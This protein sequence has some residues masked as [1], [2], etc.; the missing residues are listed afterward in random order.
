MIFFFALI[1]L[2]SEN[3]TM[4][5]WEDSKNGSESKLSPEL[6][7]GDRSPGGRTDIGWGT[8]AAEQRGLPMRMEEG[9]EKAHRPMHGRVAREVSQGFQYPKEISKGLTK[10]T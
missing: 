5:Y 8:K 10:V 4:S 1:D 7:A 9:S 3:S 2:L 6:L